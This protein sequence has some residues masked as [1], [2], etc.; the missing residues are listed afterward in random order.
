MSKLSGV[1]D[2]LFIPLVARIYV[3][4][5]FPQYFFDAKSLE[6][7]KELPPNVIE[8]KS[9]QYGLLASVARY[10]NFDDI[11]RHFIEE[12][13]EVNIINLGCGLETAYYRIADP[14]A[15]FYEIDFPEVIEHR[16][17]ALGE[18][19]KEI[20]LGY[21]LLDLSWAEHVDASKPSLMVA[22]GVFQYLHEEEIIAFLGE[23]R[24]RLPGSEILFDYTSE[25][26]IKY[27]NKYVRKTGNKDAMMYFY[28]NDVDEFAKKVDAEVLEFRVFFTRARKTI[29]KGLTLYSRIAMKV[30]DVDKRATMVRLKLN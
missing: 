27:T 22:S 19:E 20:L 16:R 2:T 28:I 9:G 21:S 10:D 8:K 18:G 3:S 11:I 17:K 23:V 4:K 26:G 5:T 14:R 7:E 12:H 24:K 15:T 29:K 1:P 25:K 13:G 6:L 30:C